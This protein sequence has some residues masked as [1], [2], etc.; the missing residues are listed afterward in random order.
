MGDDKARGVVDAN[1]AV[2]GY[3][4]KLFVAD[5]SIVPTALGL[6]PA[7]TIAAL[8]EHIMERIAAEWL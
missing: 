6:N 5:G 1:G 4:G 2:F 8:S 7:L 3:E